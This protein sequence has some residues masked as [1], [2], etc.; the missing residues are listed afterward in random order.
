MHLTFLGHSGFQIKTNNKIIYIDPYSPHLKLEKADLILIS[1]ADYDH[2]NE[3]SIRKIENRN[4]KI[5]STKEVSSK[6]LGCKTVR[7]GDE[8][9]V[10]GIHIEFIRALNPEHQDIIGFIICTEGKRIYFTSDTKYLP[11]LENIHADIVL[12][13]IGG[14]T[15][16]NFKTAAELVNKIQPMYAVPC[17][18]GSIEGTIDDALKFKALVESSRKTKV[19]VMKENETLEF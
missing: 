15:T 10:D 8:E 11:E 14:S 4:T 5:F 7:A 9:S 16:M 2:F 1:H 19:F 6:I 17:H 18:F 3:Q 13:S 12:I